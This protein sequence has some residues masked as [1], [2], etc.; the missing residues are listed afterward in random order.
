MSSGVLFMFSI[1][2][3][4]T[5]CACGTSQVE[6]SEAVKVAGSYSLSVTAAPTC[7]QLLWTQVG[8]DKSTPIDLTQNGAVITGALNLIDPPTLMSADVS[9]QIVSGNVLS[10]TLRYH[11][12]SSHVGV[13]D[14]A[15]S[16]IGTVSSAGIEGT[17]AG[18]ITEFAPFSSVAKI[19]HAPNH[20][21][22]L[23]RA[24]L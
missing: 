5:C 7:Q 12:S 22:V 24:G 1:L 18:N 17:F 8:T 6:P 14:V 20:K 3:S 11:F 15:G 4:V 23:S 2:T 16:G 13:R 9:G 10:L 21:F 19:C